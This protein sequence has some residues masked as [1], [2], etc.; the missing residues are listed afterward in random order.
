M[1]LSAG[2]SSWTLSFHSVKM[3][4]LKSHEAFLVIS[5]CVHFCLIH[6]IS[7]FFASLV[8]NSNDGLWT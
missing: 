1:G 4:A 6:I 2:P 5:F 3:F 7:W 8:Y